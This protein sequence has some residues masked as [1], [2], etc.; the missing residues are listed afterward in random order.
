VPT[1]PRA[2]CRAGPRAAALG[3][4]PAWEL[5]LRRLKAGE[6]G[7]WAPLPTA[8]TWPP[9]ASFPCSAERAPRAPF[10]QAPVA[11]R[12]PAAVA[13]ARR[14]RGGGSRASAAAAPHH[15]VA[16]KRG[17]SSKASATATSL[18][19]TPS[20]RPVGRGCGADGLTKGKRKKE[21]EGWGGKGR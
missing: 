20:L 17:R 8:P 3:E 15:R 18:G 6:K 14:S 13:S 2:S 19:P 1:L 9:Q 7:G 5:H 12:A 11:S 10:P 4:L 16:R 21:L